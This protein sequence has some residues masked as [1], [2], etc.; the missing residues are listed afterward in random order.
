V[1][2][3]TSSVEENDILNSYKNGANSYIRKPIDFNEFL[4]AVKFLGFYWLSLNEPV[5][6]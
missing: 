1:V 3:L 6:Y 2:I 5:P 4:E